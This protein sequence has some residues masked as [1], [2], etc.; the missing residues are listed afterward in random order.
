LRIDHVAGIE[1]ANVGANFSTKSNT[2]RKSE[3]N[4]RG[5]C[6]NSLPQ[7]RKRSASPRLLP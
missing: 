3:E 4:G 5:A 7:H 2:R 6:G 1:S